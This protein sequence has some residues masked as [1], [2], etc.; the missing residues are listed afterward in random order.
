MPITYSGF[1]LGK[2]VLSGGNLAE[3]APPDLPQWYVGRCSIMRESWDPIATL[4][5]ILTLK[6]SC[7]LGIPNLF[8][9]ANDSN[10]NQVL[11]N[12]TN[13]W[14]KDT[15]DKSASAGIREWSYEQ[16]PYLGTG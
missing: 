3:F 1:E 9:Y 14:V 16:E 8:A 10:Y 15:N 5:G 4:Y 2:N 12:G 6:G 11:E 13:I 7:E